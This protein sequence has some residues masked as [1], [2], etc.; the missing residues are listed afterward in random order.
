MFPYYLVVYFIRYPDLEI[1]LFAP[2]QTV[3]QTQP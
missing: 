1:R 2:M 3:L